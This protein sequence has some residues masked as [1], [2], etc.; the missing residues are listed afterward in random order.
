M[1]SKQT[2]IQRHKYI[3]G[4]TIRSWIH[5]FFSSCFLMFFSLFFAETIHLSLATHVQKNQNNFPHL[6]HVWDRA[7]F[8]R[9]DYEFIKNKREIC[10]ADLVTHSSI[11]KSIARNNHRR[12]SVF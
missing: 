10:S 7:E 2:S 8:C 3:Q 9:E 11:D 4:D 5:F 12:C 1:D 6:L